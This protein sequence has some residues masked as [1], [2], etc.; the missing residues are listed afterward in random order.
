MQVIS[1]AVVVLRQE[2]LFIVKEVIECT[3]CT[4]FGLTARCCFIFDT[5]VFFMLMEMHAFV[6]RDHISLPVSFGT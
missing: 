6:P 4:N 5:C 1:H 3:R 2:M